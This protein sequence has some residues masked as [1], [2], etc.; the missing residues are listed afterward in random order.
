MLLTSAIVAKLTP[1]VLG[2]SGQEAKE[3]AKQKLDYYGNA[4]LVTSNPG[5]SCGHP[6]AQRAVA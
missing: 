4:S 6:R 3:E 1:K 5:H 2:Y